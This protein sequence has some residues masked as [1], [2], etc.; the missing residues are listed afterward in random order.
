MKRTNIAAAT[1]IAALSLAG[2]AR[3]DEMFEGATRHITFNASFEEATRTE[4]AGA[5]KVNWSEGDTIRF[6]SKESGD[7]GTF[8]VAETNSY[9]LLE[10]DVAEN[11]KYFIAEYGGTGIKSNNDST[12]VITG[13]SMAEQDGKF[14]SAHVSVARTTDLESSKLTFKNITSLIKFDIERNDIA[15]MSF[16][17]NDDTKIQGNGDIIVSF[18]NSGNPTGRFN[19]EKAGTSIKVKIDGPGTYYIATLPVVLAKGF[20]CDF[21]AQDGKKLGVATGNNPL[22]VGKNDIENLGTL[23]PHMADG[24][25]DLGIEGTAN[26]YIVDAVGDYQFKATVKGNGNGNDVNISGIAGAKVLWESNLTQYSPGVG[27]IIKDVKY[28]NGYISFTSV[29]SG[30]AIIAAVDAEG[31]TL[32]SWHIWVALGYDAYAKGQIYLDQLNQKICRMMDRNL[33]AM[34]ADKK[35]Y[36]L[37]HG[38]MY[39]WGRKDPFL[40][41]DAVCTAY[42]FMC[43]TEEV[44]EAHGTIEYATENPLVFIYGTK[45]SDMDWIYTDHDSTLWGSEKTIYDPCPPGWRVPDEDMYTRAVKNESPYYSGI[46]DST[47]YGVDF[48][49]VMGADQSIWYPAAGYFDA[50]AKGLHQNRSRHGFYWTNATEN[51]TSGLFKVYFTNTFYPKSFSMRSYGA[52]LRCVAIKTEPDPIPVTAV[53]LEDS[54][55]TLNIFHEKILAYSITPETATDKVVSWVS[56]NTDIATVDI[57]GTV[58]AISSGDCWIKA[59]SADGPTDSCHVIVPES[60]MTDLSASESANCYIVSTPGTY[61][62]KTVKGNS[63]EAITGGVSAVA[64]WESYGN[65]DTPFANSLLYNVKYAN[66]AITFAV[67]SNMR[68][69]NAVI[70]LKDASG[71]I[72][73]SWHIWLY[74]G[75]DI[76]ESAQQYG[77]GA[78]L[79]DR[80]LGA[81]STEKN[82][83]LGIGL[84]YQWG[85]KDPFLSTRS[86]TSN[87]ASYTSDDDRFYTVP[88]SSISGN[89]EYTIA[90]PTIFISS[91]NDWDGSKNPAKWS[92]DKTIY[93]PCPAGWRVP[94]GGYY[95]VWASYVINKT[96]SNSVT[97]YHEGLWDGEKHG[98]DAGEKFGCASS[99]W[100]PASAYRFYS[101]GQIFGE[102]MYSLYWSCTPCNANA[103]A[104]YNNVDIIVLANS[105]QRA[106]GASVRCQ[107]TGSFTARPV[108]DIKVSRESLELATNGT[109]T[110]SATVTPTNATIKKIIWESSDPEYV[111]VDANGKVKAIQSTYSHT[112]YMKGEEFDRDDYTYFAEPYIEARSIDGSV[113]GRCTVSVKPSKI[114]TLW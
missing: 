90:N 4:Y 70:A 28:D 24:P 80:N 83:P 30:N 93:D 72:L 50:Y 66:G 19:E 82:N 48:G 103:Y 92:S 56:S 59:I 87:Q 105:I 23:D 106:N 91:N 63:N 62:F 53:N 52:S 36:L 44:T 71:N 37:T 27:G 109:A 110:L 60:G 47:N 101:N 41:S 12:F 64:L 1:L 31:T 75:Y 111:S 35:D 61:K 114:D 40:T 43:P 74:K 84:L 54:E 108:T 38:L 10:A 112:V 81:L 107:K 55:I 113:V 9:T 29:A 13:A 6:Y 57:T 89:I 2:C 26:C 102:G 5:G 21:Y 94:D 85:R 39:E 7:I 16:T 11:A 3:M 77:N 67:L 15:Y 100:Y 98:F 14:S 97:V 86:F 46:F 69:G 42:G 32:W 79:M 22:T 45:G 18:D 58:T 65:G 99:V 104:L 76:D 95:G 34:S 25:E 68:D 73:W 33:G 8:T 51:N 20:R 17:S 88:S 78:I 49:G 96:G